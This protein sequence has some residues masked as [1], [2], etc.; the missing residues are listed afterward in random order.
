MQIE[1]IEGA[2]KR[3]GFLKDHPYLKKMKKVAAGDRKFER[4]VH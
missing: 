2:R 3:G 1:A 4:K